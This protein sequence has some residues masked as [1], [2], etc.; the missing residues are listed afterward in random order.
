[1]SVESVVLS[2]HFNHFI[3]CRPLLLLPSRFSQ[4]QG[5]FQRVAGFI[6]HSLPHVRVVIECDLDF[7]VFNTLNR[8]LLLLSH[9]SHVQLCATP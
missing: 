8:M 7:A 4:H 3:L 2:S 6:D 1:M 9:F 5:L